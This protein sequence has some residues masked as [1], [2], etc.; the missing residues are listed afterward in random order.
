MGLFKKEDLIVQDIRFEPYAN[1]TFVPS[2]YKN[3]QIIIDYLKTLGIESIGR[4]GK[5]DYKW[6]HQAFADGKEV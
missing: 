2:I 6:T 1:I 3:R 4:F 5:W